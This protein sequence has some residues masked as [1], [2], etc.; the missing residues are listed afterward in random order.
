MASVTSEVT[1]RVHSAIHSYERRK[2][3]YVVRIRPY[4]DVSLSVGPNVQAVFFAAKHQGENFGLQTLQAS[5]KTISM[6]ENM[7]FK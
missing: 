3:M 4:V 6:K 2:E 5:V 7:W 1:R